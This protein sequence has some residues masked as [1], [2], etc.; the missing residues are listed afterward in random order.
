VVG[1][2]ATDSSLLP[3]KDKTDKAL[4]QPLTVAPA[5]NL[6]SP[7]ASFSVQSLCCVELILPHAGTA[8]LYL[9]DCTF[10]I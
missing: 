2:L 8:P 6:P 7:F 4:L 1:I 10:R 5:A 9:F 3:G